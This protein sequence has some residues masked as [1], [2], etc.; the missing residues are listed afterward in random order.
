MQWPLTFLC[1]EFS[2][3][4]SSPSLSR[5]G[6][7]NLDRFNFSLSSADERYSIS[8]GA[9]GG[10]S[11]IPITSEVRSENQSLLGNII[12]FF[13]MKTTLQIVSRGFTQS[14]DILQISYLLFCLLSYLLFCLLLGAVEP[15]DWLFSADSEPEPPSSPKWVNKSLTDDDSKQESAA[16]KGTFF[17]LNNLFLYLAIDTVFHPSGIFQNG[18]EIS[19]KFHV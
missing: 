8:H 17:F 14:S 18:M 12:V 15:L 6:S 4:S 11:K 13:F 7:L 5:K 2:G 1:F 16:C 9:T 10:S 19:S 3:A